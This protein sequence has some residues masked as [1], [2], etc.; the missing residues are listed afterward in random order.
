MGKANEPMASMLPGM[1]DLGLDTRGFVAVSYEKLF[2]LGNYQNVRV[3]V[4]VQLVD[5]EAPADAL[6]RARAWVEAQK[7]T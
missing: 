6:A 2:N 7:P 1:A 3:G 4:S 5:G